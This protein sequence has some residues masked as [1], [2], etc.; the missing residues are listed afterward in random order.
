VKSVYADPADHP[1]W[2]IDARSVFTGP[3][4]KPQPLALGD[5]PTGAPIPGVPGPVRQTP[6][7]RRGRHRA[8]D[9]PVT[10][11]TALLRDHPS[12]VPYGRHHHRPRSARTAIPMPLR[13]PVTRPALFATGYTP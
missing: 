9:R 2:I 7:R 13:R 8:G 12:G 3:R 1:L 6:G 10:V 5:L 4:P 11:I